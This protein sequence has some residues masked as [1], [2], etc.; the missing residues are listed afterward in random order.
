MIKWK[1]FLLSCLFSRTL[2]L[3]R[4]SHT[5][6]EKIFPLHQKLNFFRQIFHCDLHF[7][8]DI[9]IVNNHVIFLCCS[10][11]LNFTIVRQYNRF[12]KNFQLTLLN[13]PF[14][15]RW[16]PWPDISDSLSNG[17]CPKQS[18]DTSL[19]VLD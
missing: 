16:R 1:L 15:R 7:M 13:L 2:S 19:M 8:T 17:H 18:L 4:K 14:L 12:F 5:I 3:F 11:T 10:T 9:S 6:C